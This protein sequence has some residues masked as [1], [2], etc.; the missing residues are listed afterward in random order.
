MLQILATFLKWA[1]FSQAGESCSDVK[2]Y[3][4]F[5]RYESPSLENN[6]LTFFFEL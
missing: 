3:D 2:K 5:L 1:T 6:T 4:K